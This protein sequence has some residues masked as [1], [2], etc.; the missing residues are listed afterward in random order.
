MDIDILFYHTQSTTLN[1]ENP[2]DISKHV[3]LKH[4]HHRKQV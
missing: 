4:D 3:W 1:E 2:F